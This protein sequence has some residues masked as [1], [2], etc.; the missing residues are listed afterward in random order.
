MELGT[1]RSIKQGDRLDTRGLTT[2]PPKIEIEYAARF[3]SEWALEK[4]IIAADL[5]GKSI[6]PYWVPGDFFQSRSHTTTQK[7]QIS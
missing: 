3:K 7:D 4:D 6:S 5:L 1:P 2:L